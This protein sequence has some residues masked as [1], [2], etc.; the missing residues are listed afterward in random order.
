MPLLSGLLDTSSFLT[1]FTA[2]PYPLL[3]YSLISSALLLKDKIL[4]KAIVNLFHK[5]ILLTLTEVTSFGASAFSANLILLLVRAKDLSVNS[6]NKLIP[7]YFFSLY[8]APPTL[9]TLQYID[10]RSLFD[11]VI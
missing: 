5:G 10:I 2:S 1:K 3:T 11:L 7:R 6:P 4:S 9:G 8:V